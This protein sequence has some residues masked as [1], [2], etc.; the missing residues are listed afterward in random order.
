LLGQKDRA[1]AGRA[2]EAM[3][4]MRKIVVADLEKASAGN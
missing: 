4:G 3:M 1:A 2:M